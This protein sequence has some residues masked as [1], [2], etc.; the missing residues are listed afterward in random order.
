MGWLL[1]ADVAKYQQLASTRAIEM[2]ISSE[3]QANLIKLQNSSEKL[4]D[5]LATEMK[6][7]T[8]HKARRASYCSI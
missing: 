2:E 3:L 7:A 8:S 6:L 1:Q 5:E 4:Q